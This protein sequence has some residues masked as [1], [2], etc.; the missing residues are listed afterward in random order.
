MRRPSEPLEHQQPVKKDKPKEQSAG[1]GSS[2][3]RNPDFAEQREDYP[4]EDR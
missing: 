4:D 3:F 2:R 1:L